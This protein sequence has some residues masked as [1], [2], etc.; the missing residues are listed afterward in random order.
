MRNSIIFILLSLF[1][2]ISTDRNERGKKFLNKKHHLFRKLEES[3][4]IL[5]GFNN[6]EK[7]SNL[8]KFNTKIK[9]PSEDKISQNVVIPINIT[10]TNVEEPDLRYPN[11]TNN[12]DCINFYCTYYCSVVITN[13]NI[14]KVK[15]NDKDEKYKYKLSSLA[16][17]TKDISSKKDSD[18]KNRK[19]LDRND[20]SILDNASFSSKSGRHFVVKGDLD[21]DYVSDNIKLIVSKSTYGREL[22]CKGYKDSYYAYNYYLDCDTSISS[23]NADLQNAFAYLE[24]DDKG[25]IINFEK[26]ANST[27]TNSTIETNDYIP[28]KKS[29]GIS[30][31]GIVAIVIPC[32]LLLL[33]AVG[34]VFSLRSRAPNPPLKELANTS[35]TVGPAGASS[36]AVVHQ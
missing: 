30:T 4:G 25:F 31:G 34:L 33:L 5:M 3:E 22:P 6:F 17:I 18:T 36:E 2:I 29:K 16:N 32:I 12:T 7:K 21:S 1:L 19:I 9:Y 14:S 15:F 24:D 20:I 35:N 11:C 27:T 13:N 26:S 23:I 28:K 8:I 10:Y